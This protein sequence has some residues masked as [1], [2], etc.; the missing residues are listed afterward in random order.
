M[1]SLD[2]DAGLLERLLLLLVRHARLEGDDQLAGNG[3]AL[4]R[5]GRR[6][7]RRDDAEHRNPATT[8]A[9][10]TTRPICSLLGLR[11]RDVA[12][13]LAVANRREPDASLSSVR[14]RL[15]AEARRE[16]SHLRARER[17]S[18]RVAVGD[19]ALRRVLLQLMQPVR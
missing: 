14:A 8:P 11:A 12:P 7:R 4:L 10:H 1:T 3:L 9:A 15:R 17:E 19:V 13:V 2:L 18:L 5:L 6:R 16:L